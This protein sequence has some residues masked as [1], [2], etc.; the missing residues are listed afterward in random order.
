[1]VPKEFIEPKTKFL[2][3]YQE[4]SLS[5]LLVLAYNQEFSCLAKGNSPGTNVV[6][7][8]DP[9]SSAGTLR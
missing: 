3:P 5:I 1:M 6:Y 7:G 8:T 9:R 2:V 4:K